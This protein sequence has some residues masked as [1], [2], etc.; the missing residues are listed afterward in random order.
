V[1]ILLLLQ[2]LLDQLILGL[3]APPRP[4][5]V[6]LLD[7]RRGHHVSETDRHRKL[8]SHPPAL[9]TKLEK[10][11]RFKEEEEEETPPPPP[12]VH[13]HYEHFGFKREEEAEAP[14]PVHG[15]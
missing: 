7:Y 8:H 6:Q 2:I 1:S 3:E 13:E 9:S 10:H 11:H 12:P 14:P 15:T 4:V 5:F